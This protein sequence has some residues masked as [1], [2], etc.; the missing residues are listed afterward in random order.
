M[1]GATRGDIRDGLIRARSPRVDAEKRHRLAVAGMP[2]VGTIRSDVNRWELRRPLTS[3]R[4][5]RRTRWRT[6][7][8]E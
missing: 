1:G 8:F 5:A 3:I 6:A 7:Q 4:G 2:L